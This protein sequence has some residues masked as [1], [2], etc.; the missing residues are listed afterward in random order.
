[1]REPQQHHTFNKYTGSKQAKA[2]D[3][4]PTS[5]AQIDPTIDT[6]PQLPTTITNPGRTITPPHASDVMMPK[7]C[8]PICK[9]PIYAQR[10]SRKL[11]PRSNAMHRKHTELLQAKNISNSD[12]TEHTHASKVSSDKRKRGMPPTPRFHGTDPIRIPLL[13]GILDTY[14]DEQYTEAGAHM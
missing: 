2:A 1:M 3:P 10:V 5:C 11:P 14:T 12:P 9:S 4:S 13:T 7:N 8:D 6:T